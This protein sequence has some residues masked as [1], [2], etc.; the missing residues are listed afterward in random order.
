MHILRS[1]FCFSFIAATCGPALSDEIETPPKFVSGDPPHVE[2]T[3][4]P[5]PGDTIKKVTAK[6]GEVSLPVDFKAFRENVDAKVS[7]A[8]LIDVSAPAPRASQIKGE[9]AAVKNLLLAHP[10]N[11]YEYGIFALGKDQLVEIAPLGTASGRAV[12]MLDAYKPEG[13]TTQGFKLTLQVILKLNERPAQRKTVVVLS[14]GKF[15]DPSVGF[16]HDD[17]VKA[18]REKGIR[19]CGIGLAANEDQSRFLQVLERLAND[20]EGLYVRAAYG[21]WA[22][23][24]D[25]VDTF[26]AFLEG[27]GLAKVNVSAL[28]ENETHN[29]ALEFEDEKGSFRKLDFEINTGAAETEK[30]KDGKEKGKGEKGTEEKSKGP[31]AVKGDEPVADVPFAES[32]GFWYL[33]G[34]VV[35]LVLLIGLVALLIPRKKQVQDGTGPGGSFIPPIAFL[36]MLDARST[37]HPIRISNVRIGRGRDNDLVIQND[38][39][40]SNHCVLKQSR[41]GVWTIVDLK[42]GNGVFV[43][44]QRVE[45]AILREGDMLELGEVKMRFYEAV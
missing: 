1:F 19:V 17:V 4:R 39:V 32:P 10:E 34:G 6:S 11:F 23:P 40:S 25:F 44:D 38:S 18:A 33:I 9:I 8:F 43:N 5:A 41:D 30:E 3:L 36:E 27:G 16:G 21:T 31:V 42:S 29:I 15:E 26:F 22:L 14:D 37:R 13:Q 20:T 7:V 2:L 24:A 45:E 35:G 12:Q 28:A